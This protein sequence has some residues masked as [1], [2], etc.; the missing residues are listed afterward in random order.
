MTQGEINARCETLYNKNKKELKQFVLTL[1]DEQKKQ[2]KSH[3]ITVNNIA[4]SRNKI[5]RMKRKFR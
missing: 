3:V 4:K 5:T 1:S 2:A